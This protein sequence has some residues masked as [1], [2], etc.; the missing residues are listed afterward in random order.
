MNKPTVSSDSFYGI[1]PFEL[2]WAIGP[3]DRKVSGPEVAALFGEKVAPHVFSQGFLYMVYDLGQGAVV[4]V[5]RHVPLS[6]DVGT[7]LCQRLLLAVSLRIGWANVHQLGL[8]SY[9]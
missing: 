7:D 5:L 2:R 6:Y 4:I 1:S 9:N 3:V 8:W